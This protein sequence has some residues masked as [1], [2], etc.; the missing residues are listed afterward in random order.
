MTQP[1][2]PLDPG[3]DPSVK[4][5]HDDQVTIYEGA[6]KLRGELGLLLGWTFI[7]AICFAAPIL[8]HTYSDQ[9]ISYWAIFIGIVL[10][11]VFWSL[12]ALLVR[13]NYYRVTNYRIDYEHGLLFKNIDTLELWHVDDVSLRQSPIDRIFNVGTI[14]IVGG[15]ATTPR[16]Q[17]KSISSPRQL[18]ETLKTRI[19]AVK[20]QR[21]VV[22]LDT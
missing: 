9:G 17:L 15:D 18:L 5:A 12:P 16:L 20:R 2:P 19:I 22:K 1:I 4:A 13:R 3:P 10:A 7:G 21:G 14:T 8:I 6:P 11:I